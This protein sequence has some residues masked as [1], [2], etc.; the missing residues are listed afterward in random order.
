M[1]LKVLAV[2]IVVLVFIGCSPVGNI[3][4]TNIQ[5]ITS[6]E[7]NSFIYAL[8]RTCMWIEVEAVRTIYVAGPYHER[9]EKLLGL[10]GVIHNDETHWTIKGAKIGTYK[11]PDPDY[12]YSVRDDNYGIA[13]QELFNLGASGLVINSDAYNHLECKSESK[14]LNIQVNESMNQFSFHQ[15]EIN[16]QAIRDTAFNDIPYRSAHIDLMNKAG[17]RKSKKNSG[18]VQI[19]DPAEKA[20]QS[21]T[22]MRTLISRMFAAEYKDP[23]PSGTTA[24]AGVEILTEWEKKFL[25]LFQGKSYTDTVKKRFFIC[26]KGKESIQRFTLFNFSEKNGFVD[27]KMNEGKTVVIEITDLEQTRY[28]ELLQL[29]NNDITKQNTLFY[30]VPDKAN[31]KI[32]Y[33]SLPITDVQVSV[34]QLGA[35]VPYFVSRKMK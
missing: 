34:D 3:Y 33:G 32:L 13:Q 28:L 17:N 6:Y 19:A 11:E 24:E 23:Y 29:P 27:P 26:P 25:T 1:K 22:K 2:A 20:A 12:I 9:A 5:D 7:D 16:Y 31:V 35:V 30:R 21:V 15:A 8:P 4:T 18:K 14:P 10:S